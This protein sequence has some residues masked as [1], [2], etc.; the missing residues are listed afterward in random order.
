MITINNM[1]SPVLLRF[2]YFF[3]LQ[4]YNLGLWSIIVLVTFLDWSDN[5]YLVTL[6][7][8]CCVSPNMFLH[9]A[10]SLLSTNY[11]ASHQCRRRPTS[12]ETSSAVSLL[13]LQ[14]TTGTQLN[15]RI[16]FSNHCLHHIIHLLT[17]FYLLWSFK[18]SVLIIMQTHFVRCIMIRPWS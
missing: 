8:H 12:T 18:T 3:Y 17:R 16:S 4:F 15:I 6:T 5:E 13:Q 14:Q 2:V 9:V 11:I 7:Y 1:L 10:L